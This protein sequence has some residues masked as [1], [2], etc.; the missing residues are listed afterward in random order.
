[1]R[2]Y[3][4]DRCGKIVHSIN[5]FHGVWDRWQIFNT[6]IELCNDCRFELIIF[7]N[8]VKNGKNE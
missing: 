7:M 1:M 5:T 8:E 2:M 6:Q 3:K 4:C